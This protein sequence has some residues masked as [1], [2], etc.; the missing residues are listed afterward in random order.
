MVRLRVRKFDPASLKPHRIIIV[1]GKRGTGKCFTPDHECLTTEGWRKISDMAIGIRVLC[2]DEQENRMSYMPV[3]GV[4][5]Q[6]VSEPVYRLETDR[7]SACVT[8]NHNMYVDYG[9]GVPVLD[10]AINCHGARCSFLTACRGGLSS[11]QVRHTSL[12]DIELVNCGRNIRSTGKPLPEWC[13]H[14]DASQSLSV[15]VGAMDAAA[16]VEGSRQ[17]QDDF[18]RLAVHAGLSATT[19]STHLQVHSQ[20]DAPINQSGR[21][22][23]LEEYCGDVHCITVPTHIFYMRHHGKAMWCGNS[24]LQRDLLYHLSQKLDFGLAMTPT[25]ESADTFRCHMPDSWIYNGFSTSKLDSMLNMQRE[26]VKQKKAR[27]LFIVLDDCMYDKKILKGLGIRDLFMNGRHLNITL[28]NAVQ[29]VMDMGPDLRTQVDYVFALRENIISNKNKLWK[30][31]FGMFEKYDDFARVMD[32]C[33]ENH[34][35]IV[36]DNTTGSCNVEE[37]IFWYKATIDLPD[38]KIGKPIYWKL[39]NDYMKTE[40]DKLR[41]EKQDMEEKQERAEP[42]KRISAVHIEGKENANEKRLLRL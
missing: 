37:C 34:S 7:L 4:H 40:E 28:C 14:L 24:V 3:S 6:R 35:C 26:M 8:L 5:C 9:T 29:Y 25:E 39:S 42:K 33:T 10:H 15:L 1:V 31:F 16:R 27:S 11:E 19:G 38:F 13:F 22:D 2:Y 18:Q 36:M 12:T 20:A 41:E 17:Q 23:S 21:D 32:K 30:Y